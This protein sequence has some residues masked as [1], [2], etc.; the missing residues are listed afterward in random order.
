MPE[1]SMF[2]NAEDLQY[3]IG[4]IEENE[5]AMTTAARSILT[6]GFSGYVD[7]AVQNACISIAE[8]IVSIK[9]RLDCSNRRGFCVRVVKNK[10]IDIIRRNSKYKKQS[11]DDTDYAIKADTPTPLDEVLVNE[12]Y[13]RIIKAIKSLDENYS[14]VLIY[15]L[16]DGFSDMEIA[17][18]LGITCKNVNVR[19]F[20]AKQKLCLLLKGD[21][22]EDL[23]GKGLQAP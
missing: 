20:R 6:G 13:E 8:N 22:G 3:Y 21:E 9:N 2:K 1:M 4:L 18:L 15:K 17:Q 10:S 19:T 11:L 7:D 23:D 12:G 5:A 14:S 16:V